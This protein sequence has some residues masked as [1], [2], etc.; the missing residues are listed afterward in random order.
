M[1]QLL[2]SY[3]KDGYYAPEQLQNIQHD[4]SN[5]T[6]YEEVNIKQYELQ[7]VCRYLLDKISNNE[8]K[9]LKFPRIETSNIQQKV[10]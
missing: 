2:Y 7:N 10:L 6:P 5:E 3:L 4:R 8:E 9:A 1:R